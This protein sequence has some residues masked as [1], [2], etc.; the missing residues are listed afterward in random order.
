MLLW[1]SPAA[2]RKITKQIFEKYWNNS[3]NLVITTEFM[4]ADWFFKNPIGVAKHLLSFN[5]TPVLKVL[6]IAQ[7]FGWNEETLLY[8]AKRIHNNLNYDLVELNIWCPSPKICAIGWWSALM[9]DKEKTLKIIEKLSQIT[10]WNFSIK[11]RCWL[12]EYDKPQQLKFI[13]K[14]SKFCKIITIHWRTFKQWHSGQV[15]RNFIYK[16]KEI[17]NSNC[18]IIWNWWIK[19]YKEIFEKLNNLDGIS[20]WQAA[21]W[22]PW[23]FTLYKPD[24]K[25]KKETILKHLNLLIFQNI[26]WNVLKINLENQSKEKV[27][28]ILSKTLEFKTYDFSSD[29]QKENKNISEKLTKLTDFKFKPL[30]E[31]KLNFI[32]KYSIKEFR[33]HFFAYLKWIPNSKQL[34]QEIAKIESYDEIVKVIEK[35]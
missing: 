7:I 32:I 10:N 5:S 11:T 9:K 16:A 15:D 30:D 33:K 29:W 35:I 24:L 14:A 23:V 34:K 13:K 19:S 8:T 1:L 26:Y 28:E 22:N 3:Y 17:S 25:N 6:N 27:L 21:I 31:N 18:K 4:S 12:D 20:I 2:Y